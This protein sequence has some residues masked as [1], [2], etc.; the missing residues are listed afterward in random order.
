MSEMILQARGISMSYGRKT[1][2][3]GLELGVRRGE[4]CGLLG[5]NGAGKTTLLKVLTGLARPD[6][7]DVELFGKP[8]AEGAL[9]KTG[10]IIDK[11]AYYG[12]KTAREN[13]A[14]HQA[15][16]GIPENRVEHLLE[17]VGLS[18]HAGSKVAKFSTGMKQRLAIAMALMG[19]PRL[20]ILDEPVNSLDTQG[21]AD[22]R[23]LFQ[24][25]NREMG[26]T[27]LITSHLLDEVSRLATSYAILRGGAAR[28]YSAA[29]VREKSRQYA[30]IRTGSPRAAAV[31][32]DRFVQAEGGYEV[33]HGGDI[34]L[35]Q[36]LDRLP[37]INAALVEGGVPVL[38]LSLKTGT[39]AEFYL[40]ETAKGGDANA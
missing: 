39:L 36:S 15:L 14:I 5:P 20:L 31:V 6:G 40:E 1:V 30:E 7:G 21:M 19:R 11:P 26:A 8:F 29:E 34:H 13:L 35:Y 24:E 10:A 3:K 18:E 9:R 32:L 17:Q 16:L 12:G 23:A 27:I 4:V 22:M 2:L 28:Q 33:A 37:E 38:S 25:L